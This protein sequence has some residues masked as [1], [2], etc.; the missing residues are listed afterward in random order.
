[1]GIAGAGEDRLPNSRSSDR[2]SYV[3]ITFASLLLTRLSIARVALSG[4]MGALRES[5]DLESESKLVFVYYQVAS[6]LHLMGDR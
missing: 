1:M 3:D 4:Q 2:T 6:N 5:L